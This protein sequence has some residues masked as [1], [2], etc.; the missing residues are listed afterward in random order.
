MN[1]SKIDTELSISAIESKNCIWNIACDEYK[2]RDIKNAA[3][4]EVAAVVVHKFDRTDTS[5]D[6][7]EAG[8]ENQN[9][10]VVDLSESDADVDVEG[11]VKE[12][13]LRQ[14]FT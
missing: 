2:N 12:S 10:E 6:A 11:S 3:F 1:H 9:N 4:L 14:N 5:F 8:Q 13:Q 7:D